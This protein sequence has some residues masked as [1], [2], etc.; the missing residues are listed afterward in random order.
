[1]SRVWKCITSGYN[2]VMTDLFLV[3]FRIDVDLDW[4]PLRHSF[5]HPSHFMVSYML[6]TEKTIRD[7]KMSLKPII[8]R[9]EECISRYGN[10]DSRVIIFQFVL[11]S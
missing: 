2:K 10:K 3:G 1:M 5:L 9:A 7:R 6:L 8:V 11:F 4:Y